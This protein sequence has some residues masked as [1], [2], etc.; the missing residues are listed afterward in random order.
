MNTQKECLQIIEDCRL[1]L[2]DV[3]DILTIS[4]TGVHNKKYLKQ[5]NRFL[6]RDLKKLEKHKKNIH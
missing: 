5:G 2:T 6:D 3:A 1:K 4:I